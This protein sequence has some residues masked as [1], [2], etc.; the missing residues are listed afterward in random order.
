MESNS[1]AALAGLRP[2]SD[3]IIGADTLM[4]E[5]INLFINTKNNLTF[6]H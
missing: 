6:S 4:N 3:Y 2:H 5:V 1:P